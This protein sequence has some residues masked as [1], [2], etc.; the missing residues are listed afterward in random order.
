MNS[1]VIRIMIEKQIEMAS[2]KSSSAL[3]SG[4]M[5]MTRMARMPTAIATSLRRRRRAR[6]CQVRPPD[7]ETGAGEEEADVSAI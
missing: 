3:G 1:A 7:P 6:P 2:E 4:R 5:S